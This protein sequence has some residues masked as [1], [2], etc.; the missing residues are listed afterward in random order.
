MFDREIS[1]FYENDNRENRTVH[2]AIFTKL[3]RINSYIYV[4]RWRGEK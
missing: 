1:I 3:I 2:F 4:S